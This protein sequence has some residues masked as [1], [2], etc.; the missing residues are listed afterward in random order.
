MVFGMPLRV[1][2]CWL[3]FLT[4]FDRMMGVKKMLRI[5]HSK[6]IGI[7]RTDGSRAP[8]T[9]LA[10]ASPDLSDSQMDVL[11]PTQQSF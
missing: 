10:A 3:Y 8:H 7:S 11:L 9:N 5:E 4:S 2:T 1:I 6:K